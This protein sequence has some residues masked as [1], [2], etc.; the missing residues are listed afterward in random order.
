M[1]Y[2]IVEHDDGMY[3]VHKQGEQQPIDGGCHDSEQDAKDHMAALYANEKSVSHRV[4]SGDIAMQI[5]RTPQDR[6]DTLR[7]KLRELSTLLDDAPP[8]KAV[9]YNEIISR[10]AEAIYRTIRPMD[11]YCY[12]EF[13]YD[14]YAIV[15][16]EGVYYRVEYTISDDDVTVPP[17][18][19]WQRVEREWA[20]KR[21]RPF[22]IAHGSAV[23]ALDNGHLG[24]YLVTFGAPDQTD[25]AGDFFTKDTDFGFEDE[26][27][28]AVYFN[29]RLPLKTRGGDFFV[30]KSKIGEATLTKDERGILIDAI[31]FNRAEYEAALA[32]LGW[33]SGTADHLV[34]AEPVGKAYWLK[35]WP[36]GLD[37]SLTPTPAEPRNSVIPIKALLTQEPIVII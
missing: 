9:S 36:L 33:S 27:K 7:T 32:A 16:N 31:L 18:D 35:S 12:I 17:M 25:L 4:F 20:A 28:T 14:T 1:P 24:G 37:A 30:I 2:E 26:I 34:E 3:C 19:D 6:L 29:H 15:N 22:R 11:M 21:A 5:K 13:V 10:V 23:K 8:I